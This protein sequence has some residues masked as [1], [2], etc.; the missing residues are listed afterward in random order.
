[1]DW[2]TV[3]SKGCNRPPDYPVAGRDTAKSGMGCGAN[4]H[5]HDLVESITMNV[6]GSDMDAKVCSPPMPYQSV[7][8]PIG[9]RARESRVHGE[10]GQLV[11]ISTQK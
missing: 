4:R 10:G 3:Q 6:G 7:G 11:E 2:V 8:G 5:L 9:V 1:M